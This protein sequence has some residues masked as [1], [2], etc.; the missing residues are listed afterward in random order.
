[1]IKVRKNYVKLKLPKKKRIKME[2]KL[3][4]AL[5][6]IGLAAII[7]CSAYAIPLQEVKMD[8]NISTSVIP[9]GGNDIYDES[10]TEYNA[11]LENS[12]MENNSTNGTHKDL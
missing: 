1:M 9:L 5:F 4:C 2:T 6:A 8:K 12:S 7:N 10:T 3:C 11:T